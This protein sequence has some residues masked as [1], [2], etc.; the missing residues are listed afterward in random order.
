MEATIARDILKKDVADLREGVVA[1]HGVDCF[2]K[3]GAACFIDAARICPGPLESILF[4][5]KEEFA[6]FD[7][8]EVER[9][10]G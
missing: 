6:E 1:K 7:G 4:C 8:D 2:A 5:L 3:L 10:Y 9:I